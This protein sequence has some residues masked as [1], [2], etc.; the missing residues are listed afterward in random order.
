M[1]ANAVRMRLKTVKIAI[2]K[3]KPCE[4]VIWKESDLLVVVKHIGDVVRVISLSERKPVDVP[5]EEVV[6]KTGKLALLYEPEYEV[7][8]QGT[9]VRRVE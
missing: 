8:Q 3:V 2:G 6:E 4:I 7:S 1:L 5:A 9:T